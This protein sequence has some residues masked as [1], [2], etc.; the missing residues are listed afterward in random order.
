VIELADLLLSLGD[1]LSKLQAS[2]TKP[3]ENRGKSYKG[4]HLD[5]E[6][7]ISMKNFK[8]RTE[9]MSDNN[10]D[11]SKS[12]ATKCK[13]HKSASSVGISC[14]SKRAVTGFRHMCWYHQLFGTEY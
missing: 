4:E 8:A 14:V 1:Y 12:K 3:K 7:A 2:S 10:K 9:V 13:Q 5:F 11:L 6:L